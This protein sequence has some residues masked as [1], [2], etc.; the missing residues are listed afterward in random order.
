MSPRLRFGLYLVFVH[1]LFAALAIW[2]LRD[3]PILLLAA[4]VVLLASCLAGIALARDLFAG[5]TLAA[6]RR[7]VLGDRVPLRTTDIPAG[8]LWSAVLLGDRP[9]TPPFDFAAIGAP[10]CSLYLDPARAVGSVFAGAP[11]TVWPVSIPAH[12]FALGLALVA[13]SAAV[14]P[15]ANALGVVTSNGVRLVVGPY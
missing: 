9:L 1:L 7:P 15:G 6:D 8:A 5:L 2:L 4:E 10:E 11:T 14:V 12:P 13:Q 3:R